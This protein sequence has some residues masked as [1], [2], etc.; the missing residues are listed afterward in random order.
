MDRW[1]RFE[2]GVAVV[3]HLRPSRDQVARALL[4]RQA[5]HQRHWQRSTHGRTAD[6]TALPR[7]RANKSRRSR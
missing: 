7:R 1:T 3:L 6:E 4:E 5:L 2:G